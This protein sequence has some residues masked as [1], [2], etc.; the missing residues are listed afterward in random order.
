MRDPKRIEPI[1]GLIREIWY[2]YPSLRLTQLIMNA[3]EM[4]SDPYYVE[5]S[6]LEKA[7]KDLKKSLEEKKFD[8]KPNIQD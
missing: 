6:K 3:L 2:R 7:L 5:D 1:L 8:N 4:N